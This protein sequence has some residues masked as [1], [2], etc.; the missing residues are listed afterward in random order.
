MPDPIARPSIK[1][2][3]GDAPLAGDNAAGQTV[4]LMQAPQRRNLHA[5][6]ERRLRLRQEDHR[7]AHWN[8]SSA[9]TRAAIA[10]CASPSLMPG[11]VGRRVHRLAG[12]LT[13]SLADL[14]PIVLVERID[15][16]LEAIFQELRPRGALLERVGTH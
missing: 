6:P 1:I 8:P 5:Q 14:L 13:L 4:I 9:W 12:V 11:V 2:A 10:S 15:L 7:P 16:A 3:G